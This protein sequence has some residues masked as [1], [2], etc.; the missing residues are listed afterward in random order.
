MKRD[1]QSNLNGAKR[2]KCK[3]FNLLVKNMVRLNSRRR[4]NLLKLCIH[5]QPDI[6][7]IFTSGPDK[8]ISEFINSGSLSSDVP[9]VCQAL[10]LMHNG[11]SR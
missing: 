7:N 4:H 9:A 11:V 5:V 6:Y 1:K 2:L 3:H 10:K 8:L